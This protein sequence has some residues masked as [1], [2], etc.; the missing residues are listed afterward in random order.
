MEGVTIYRRTPWVVLAVVFLS[1]GGRCG[2]GGEAARPSCTIDVPVVEQQI[3]R[4]VNE[5]DLHLGGM[6]IPVGDWHNKKN[7]FN[8][9]PVVVT[10]DLGRVYPVAQVRL[11]SKLRP[12]HAI[13]TAEL[14]VA[15]DPEEYE[16][17]A[18]GDGPEPSRT[19]HSRFALEAD[20]DRLSARYVRATVFPKA[21]WRLDPGALEI[22]LA[23]SAEVTAGIERLAGD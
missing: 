3:V 6:R 16:V 19:E 20:C 12:W 5:G 4:R 21:F 13:G 22:E 14:A 17:L 8:A 1:A 7:R 11:L 2:A 18:V 10:V 23:P 15:V 9:R